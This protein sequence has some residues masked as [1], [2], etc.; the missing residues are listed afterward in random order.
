MDYTRPRI[1]RVTFTNDRHERVTLHLRSADLAA[2]IARDKG[3][4]WIKE[5]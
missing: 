1:N 5:I 2:R 4:T 3:G